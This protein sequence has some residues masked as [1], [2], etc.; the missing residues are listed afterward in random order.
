MIYEWD[1]RKR[2]VNLEKH[3]LDFADAW[4]VFEAAVK[5]TLSESRTRSV[6]ARRIDIA[7]V[8][9]VALVLV[10]TMRGDSVRIISFRRA[11]R[12]ERRMFHAALEDR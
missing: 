2:I 7:E 12:K 8:A 9:D 3:G 10:Y 4:M 1:E 11:K 5:I 6:E